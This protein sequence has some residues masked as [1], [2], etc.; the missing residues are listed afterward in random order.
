MYRVGLRPKT[1]SNYFYRVRKIFNLGEPLTYDRAVDLIEK[2]IR[3]KSYQTVLGYRKALKWFSKWLYE[4][5]G[6]IIDFDEIFK[7]L[8]VKWTVYSKIKYLDLSDKDMIKAYQILKEHKMEKESILFAFATVTGM[9]RSEILQLEKKHIDLDNR[10]V[11]GGLLD[12]KFIRH[13]KK[14]FFTFFTKEVKELINKIINSNGPIFKVSDK[15]LK[16]AYQT[17]EKH[18][19]KRI[20]LQTCREFFATKLLE[21]G[22]F[23]EIEVNIL[24]GRTRGIIEKHYFIANWKKLRK[25]YD[26]VWSNFCFEN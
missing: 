1:A 6:V 25:K 11:L 3:T 5:Y 13:T 21:S 4:T 26:K 19:G 18:L 17:I 22:L 10:I 2:L 15:K 8:G 7:K 9:R 16:I 20:T 23:S 24:Q 12:E 14:F